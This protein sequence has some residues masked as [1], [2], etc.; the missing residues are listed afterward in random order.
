MAIGMPL[1]ASANCFNATARNFLR[2]NSELWQV[3]TATTVW[4]QAF[5]LITLLFYL[6]LRSVYSLI[7]I[8]S[9]NG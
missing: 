1:P 3:S 9:I 8:L 2:P 4:S 7:P 6:F 5:L